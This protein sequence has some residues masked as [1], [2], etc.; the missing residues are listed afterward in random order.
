MTRMEKKIPERRCVGC[1]ESFPKRDLI[2][3]V[4]TPEGTVTL[5]ATGKQNGRGVYVCRRSE[6]FKNARKK[7]RF[8]SN[9]GV[10]IPEEVLDGIEAQ[11]ASFEK[12]AGASV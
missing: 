7:R 8:A 10:E 9:L 1:G 6:C 11:I 4:R 5:D 12:E 2:R 3:V